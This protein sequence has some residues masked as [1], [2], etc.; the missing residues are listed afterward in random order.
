MKI[1]TI[2]V[3]LDGVDAQGNPTRYMKRAE[4][5]ADKIPLALIEGLEERKLGMARRALARTLGLNADEAEQLT[6]EHLNQ[7]TDALNAAREIPNG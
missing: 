3:E 7:F 2:E 1:V 6:I 5:R 4:L